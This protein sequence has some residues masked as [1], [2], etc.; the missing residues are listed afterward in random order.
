MARARERSEVH[1]LYGGQSW[2]EAHWPAASIL[3][4][5][6]ATGPFPGSIK[7]ERRKRVMR[8]SKNGVGRVEGFRLPFGRAR[9]RNRRRSINVYCDLPVL[10]FY[11]IYYMLR[12]RWGTFKLANARFTMLKS[13]S[14]R[15]RPLAK[16]MMGVSDSFL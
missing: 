4:T 16:M 8:Y 1:R 13:P 14:P 11:I 10:A 9:Y 6:N 12:Q 2:N 3:P 7:Q 15:M 5:F